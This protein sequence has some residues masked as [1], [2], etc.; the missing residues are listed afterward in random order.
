MSDFT[1]TILQ[2]FENLKSQM[3]LYPVVLGGYAASGGGAGTPPG[4]FVGWLPQTRVTYD[5][6]EAATSGV[7]PSGQ[8]LL[9]NLNRIRYRLTVLESGGSGIDIKDDGILEGSSI[10]VLDFDTNLD[11]A[12]VGDTATITAT[13]SGGGGD[14]TAIHD[15]VANE[16]TAI[17][18]KTTL[19][20]ADELILED[21]AASFVKK[22][23]TFG[24]LEGSVDH[25]NVTNTHNLSTDIDHDGLTNTHNLST[26]IDHDGLTN[27]HNLSTDIDH[28]TITNKGT[29][30]HSVID[31]HLGLTDEHLNWKNSV[32][33]IHTDNYIEGGAGT[34]TTAIHDNVANEITG[35][36]N[37]ATLVAADELLIEDSEATYAKKAVTFS[38][39]EGEIDHANITNT[40]NLSTDID[41]NGLTNTHNLT[42]DV[43]HDT[44]TNR[45]T[46]AHS[47]IDSH[48]ASTANPHSVDETDVLPSQTGHDGKFLQTDGAATSWVVVSGGTGDELVGVDSGATP[49]YL[50]ALYNEGVL[51]T[52]TGIDKADGGDFITLTTDDSE[53]DHNSLNNH[54]ANE[55]LDWTASVGTIHTDNYI[56]GGA[57]TDTD[58]LHDNVANEIT[59]ITPKTTLVAADEL[60]LEDSG[61]AFVKKAVTFANLE[62]SVDH[63]NI[64][65]SHN[66]S[67]D[68]DHNGLTNTHNLSTDI[69]HNGLTNTHNLTTSI[70]HNTIT[71]NH[72]L[73]TDIAHDG[74]TSGTIAAHDTSATGAELDTLTDGSDVGALHTHSG[75]GDS[76]AI[77]DNVANEIT[78]ITPKTTLAD[79]D[80]FLL[81]DSAA[82]F[83]KKAI[84]FG[85]LEGQIDHANVTN[86][87][88]LTTD[89]DHNTITNNHNLTTDIDHD[90][91]TNKGTNAHSVI[92]T[93][94]GLTNEHIDWSASA[95]GTIHTDNYIEGGAGTDTTAIHDNV[96]NEITGIAT[97]ATPVA[98]D[99]LL[100][101]DSAASYV[102]KAVLF[103][104]F[105]GALTHDNLN[106]VS[107]NEHIDWE[108][109]SAG[110]IHTDNYIEGGAGTDT[111]A[112][113][114]NV[115]NEITGITPKT[116]LAASDEFI[117]EDSGASFVK[118]AVT[119]A[120]LEGTVS[121]NNIADV[122]ANEHIDWTAASAN[123]KTSGN[124]T[125]NDAAPAFTGQ[126]E[127]LGDTV[128][129]QDDASVSYRASVYS[130]T[131][132]YTPR[133]IAV[134]AGGDA[135]SPTQTIS[136]MVMF[137]LGAQGYASGFITNLGAYIQMSAT[138]SWQV[139]EH[140][141]DLKIYTTNV[142]ANIA[143]E[144]M[145]FNDGEIVING[146]GANHNLVIKNSA[147]TNLFTFDADYGVIINDA[148]GNYNFRAE[149]SAGTNLL[150]IDADVGVTINDGA[151]NYDFVVKGDTDATLINTDA[152][153]NLVGIG[154]AP[155]T[156][157]HVLSSTTPQFRVAYDATY[158]ANFSVSNAGL[159]TITPT[160]DEIYLNADVR[161]QD[162]FRLTRKA[163]VKISSGE[164]AYTT[165]YILVGAEGVATTDTLQS[166]TGGSAGDL[167]LIKATGGDIIT[168]EDNAGTG[169]N[170]YLAGSTDKTLNG[171]Q[172]D[173]L[174]LVSSGSAWYQ[175]AY[176]DN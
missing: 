147:S 64:T 116:T 47:V 40:H 113:H 134:R 76:D 32:G 11:V 91:I 102:K 57:G 128:I 75:I 38:V 106:G 92:D 158:Y 23:V 6:S 67:T 66:L 1:F 169:T 2:Y 124:A 36:A 3:K 122:T 141:T 118:K 9:H 46:N 108:A 153:N 12:V 164:I 175:V 27:T 15:D 83:V 89:I 31:T 168:V 18:P 80:E 44:I 5:K 53:I 146:A 97:K 14:A 48:L 63:A 132:T 35:I 129:Y 145:A 140:G 33:T 52:S 55:H 82:S 95:A 127:V 120:N 42:T 138:Q 151:G 110:T 173:H 123:F 166:I 100:I 136:T 37:K 176:S 30:A 99:E 139:A 43:D 54:V 73:T 71:N 172:G 130:D 135:S 133:L 165:A 93:H 17:T 163:E 117:L 112:I 77:H 20:A 45:G 119:F 114:D 152:A 150:T 111:T 154:V 121:H 87:H 26:D 167:F 13:V 79:A 28:D 96:A 86:T 148:G 16:I 62:G 21:S 88:N 74:I 19:V 126:L 85:N 4:G 137:T 58:A 143:A 159:L 162:E 69:D 60:V 10:T 8:S 51:R 49:G 94:L 157:L 103:S 61:A 84:T 131:T 160:G 39:L 29:N 50:G 101:E 98:A 105:E 78:G 171:T 104:A 41:H 70:D 149:S 34:D 56:E 59:G 174:L 72:N 109:S 25:A 144:R 81:E 24:N 156:K 7:P 65:N 90:Q 125:I 142:G 170:I 22:A 155:A 161:V 68:I 107:A 115:A